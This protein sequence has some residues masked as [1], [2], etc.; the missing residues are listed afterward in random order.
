MGWE[1][2]LGGL[3]E[4]SLLF[5]G[6]LD[7]NGR[8]RWRDEVDMSLDLKG[9][10]ILVTSNVQCLCARN[11]RRRDISWKEVIQAPQP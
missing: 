7:L 2:W 3:L 5:G 11:A 1:S 8:Y 4:C 10:V 6:S 9:N